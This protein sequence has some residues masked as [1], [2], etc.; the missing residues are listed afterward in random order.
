MVTSDANRQATFGKAAPAQML[1]GKS[2]VRE[3][4]HLAHRVTP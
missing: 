2:G 4:A 1:A 3:V